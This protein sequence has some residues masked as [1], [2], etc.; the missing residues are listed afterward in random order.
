MILF[1]G[2]SILKKAPQY[3]IFSIFTLFVGYLIISLI[4]SN[5]MRRDSKVISKNSAEVV[6][7]VQE[8][9][10]SFREIKLSGFE[11][12]FFNLFSKSESKLRISD[13]NIRIF[14]DLPRF[15][16]EGLILSM[17][18]ILSAVSVSYTHLTLPT[19]CAV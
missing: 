4:T 7:I 13:S 5:A 11:N 18:I 14:S 9:V 1:I 16:I 17:I 12:K 10:S 3:T 15:V 19:T 8:S 6:K 2:I